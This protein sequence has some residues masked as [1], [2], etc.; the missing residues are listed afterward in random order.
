MSLVHNLLYNQKDISTVSSRSYL[1]SLVGDIEVSYLAEDKTVMF[2]ANI[3]DAKLEVAKAIPLGILVNEIIVNAIKHA[4]VGIQAGLI[5]L[6]FKMNAES[7]F[8]SISD[9]GIGF[10]KSEVNQ[11]LGLELIESLVDQLD[12]EIELKI[13]NGTHFNIEIPRN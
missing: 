6:E 2:E 4:F 7:F 11:G 10:S 3:E 8:L 12:G 13:E 5:N 1:T 9:N